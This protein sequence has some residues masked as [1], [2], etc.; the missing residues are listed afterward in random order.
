MISLYVREKY[1][2]FYKGKQIGKC[3]VYSN[4]RVGY[5][6][7]GAAEEFGDELRS[8]GLDKDVR[9]GGR[10][11]AA[12]IFDAMKDAN[13]VPGT[14]KQAWQEGGLR[15]ERIPEDVDKFWIYRRSAEKG[16]AGYSEKD[17]SAPH[18]EGG[19]QPEG[20]REWASWYCFNKKDDGMYEA[21][22]DEAWWW[23][24][25]HNDGGTI[26]REVPEEWLSLPYDDFLEHVV[27][28]SSAA[29]YGFTAEELKEKEGLKA[30]FG[31]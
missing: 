4:S 14:R 22:L 30:F 11:S 19:K 12:A 26:R 17:H 20:M 5:N 8:L 24:G 3:F 10:S 27:T 23:G 29:H 28:L 16:E 13:R 31:Y 6:A 18:F 1:D 25:G 9:G 21:E 15:V 2:V 7:F